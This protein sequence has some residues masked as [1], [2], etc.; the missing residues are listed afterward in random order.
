[1]MPEMDGY[2]L[3]RALREQEKLAAI[4]IIVISAKS[5]PEDRAAVQEAGADDLLSKP[6][7]VK[8]LLH[9]IQ[10]HFHPN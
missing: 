6:F 10:H 2:S 3:V 9:C 7:T 8:E 1:M 4:P 5:L